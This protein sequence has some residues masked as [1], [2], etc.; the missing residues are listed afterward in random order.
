MSV[1]SVTAARE[2]DG[3]VV[4]HFGG[5]DDGRPNRLRIMDGWNFIVRLYRPHAEVLDGRWT[6]PSLETL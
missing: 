6:F 4:V 5:P 3:G 2:A 1:N